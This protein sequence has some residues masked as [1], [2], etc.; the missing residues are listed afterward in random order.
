[1]GQIFGFSKRI[2]DS[3]SDKILIIMKSK[4]FTDTVK[5]DLNETFSTIAFKYCQA[6]SFRPSSGIILYYHNYEIKANDTPKSLGLK[7][8][9]TLKVTW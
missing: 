5:V 9:T 4:N 3:S 6:E 8:G 2:S 7:N 1:M